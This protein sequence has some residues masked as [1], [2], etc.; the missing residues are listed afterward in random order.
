MKKYSQ[1]SFLLITV[2]CFSRFWNFWK[3]GNKTY[4]ELFSFVASFQFPLNFLIFSNTK[5]PKTRPT[6]KNIPQIALRTWLWTRATSTIKISQSIWSLTPLTWLL[7]RE[8]RF[9]ARAAWPTM[10]LINCLIMIGRV[11]CA[12]ARIYHR[13]KVHHAFR[14]MTRRSTISKVSLAKC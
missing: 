9:H 10:F 4:E 12:V 3:S 6:P 1:I 8:N 2:K 14:K 11:G 5:L 13:W 7:S